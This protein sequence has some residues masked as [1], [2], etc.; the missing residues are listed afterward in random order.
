VLVSD[1]F[2]SNS[3]DGFDFYDFWDQFSTK[4][5]NPRGVQ[6]TKALNPKEIRL[7]YV[8]WAILDSNQ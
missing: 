2:A 3:Y 5:K 8:L 4:L 6:T 7:L 1:F